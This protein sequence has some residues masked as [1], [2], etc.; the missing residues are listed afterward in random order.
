MVRNLVAVIAV[1]CAL[2]APSAEGA[3]VDD[4][5]SH[6]ARLAAREGGTARDCA[7]GLYTLTLGDG[8][9]ASMRVTPGSGRGRK[10]LLLALHGAG[11]SSTDGLWAFRGAMARRNVV[12]VAPE[13]ESRIW[14]PFYGSD[15]DSINRALTRVFA[16]CRVDPRRIAV[17]GFSDGAGNALTL[18]VLNGDLFRA[19][20]ALSPG[21]MQSRPAVGKPRIFIAHGTSSRSVGAASSHG[22]FARPAMR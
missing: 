5:Q 13:S 20:I 10:A 17:G 15:L 12:I 18:G 21:G 19:V 16:R 1:T 6:P 9:I 3:A 14:N 4:M 2:V 8:R 11:G 22:P 7:P